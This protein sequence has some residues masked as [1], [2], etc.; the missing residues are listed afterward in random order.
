MG[1]LSLSL[2]SLHGAARVVNGDVQT[3]VRLAWKTGDSF[4]FIF[5]ADELKSKL[6]RGAFF[7]LGLGPFIYWRFKVQS[8]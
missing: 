6:F 8:I 7:E 2:W 4:S 5:G 1:A 3:C